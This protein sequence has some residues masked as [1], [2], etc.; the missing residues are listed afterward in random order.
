MQNTPSI[1]SRFVSYKPYE[2]VHSFDLEFLDNESY[3]LARSVPQF[4]LGRL[5]FTYQRLHFV[6][7]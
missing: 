4:R 6:S 2:V 7:L 1:S 5:S 3:K